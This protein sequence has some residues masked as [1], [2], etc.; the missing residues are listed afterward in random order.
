MEKGDLTRRVRVQSRD[1]IGELAHAFNAMADGLTR[2]EQGRRRMVTDVAHELRTPLTN[3]RG[4]LEALQDGVAQPTPEVIQSLQE[5]ALLLSRLVDGLQELAL[6]EAGQLRLVRQPVAVDALIQQAVYALQPVAA[7]KGLVVTCAAPPDLPRTI[8]D[9]ERV[10]QVLRN[11]LHN[12]MTHTP[13]GGRITVDAQVRDKAI[14][15]RV[16]DTGSGIAPGDLPQI[17]DRFFRADRSRARATGGAGLGLAIVRQLVELHGGQVWAESTLGAGSTFSFT[18][19]IL[20]RAA[21]RPRPVVPTSRQPAPAAPV[22]SG[23]P[24]RSPAARN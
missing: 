14:L 18:L 1:E 21:R 6:A 16:Q 24:P 19:P 8:A 17:F 7:D 13:P 4:Y 20:R 10:G 15:V 2:L 23:E 3:L 11:L 9:P 5:E 22:A 12:A